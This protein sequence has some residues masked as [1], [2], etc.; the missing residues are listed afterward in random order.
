VLSFQEHVLERTLFDADAALHLTLHAMSLATQIYECG[1]PDA[2]DR[3]LNIAEQALAAT[4][5][6]LAR[7]QALVAHKAQA[8]HMGLHAAAALREEEDADLQDT[9]SSSYS[10]CTSAASG[11]QC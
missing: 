6:Q 8:Q 11:P 1:A 3:A 9:C 10:A 2:A 7:A 4:V 5:Q